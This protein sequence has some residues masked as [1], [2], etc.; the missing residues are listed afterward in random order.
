MMLKI[1]ST[2]LAEPK[3]DGVGV[4]VDSRAGRDRSK[5]DESGISDVE[6]PGGKVRDNEVRKKNSKNV[7]EVRKFV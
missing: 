5:L 6:I 1:S 2:K 7:Y 3:K 4:G